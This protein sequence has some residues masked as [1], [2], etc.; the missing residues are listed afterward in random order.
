MSP[1]FIPAIASQS[2]GRAWH[3][4]LEHR[5]DLCEKYGFKAIELFFE[6]LEAIA[7]ALPVSCPPSPSGT[8]FPGS[9]DEQERQLAAA[10]YIHGLCADHK[11]AILCLQPFMHYEGRLDPVSHQTAIQNLHFWIRLAHRLGTDLIQIPSNF[12]PSSYCTGDRT[13]IVADLRQV[14]DI[15]LDASPPIRFAYEALCW[16][17]HID[18]W[19]AAWSIVLE[20]G[21][22]NFGTCIDT[23]NLAGRVFADPSSPSGLVPHAWDDL[24]R[25]ISKLRAELPRA[26]GKVFYVEVCDGERLDKP[27]LPGHEWYD[28]EQPVRMSWSRNA[29]LFPFEKTGYLPVLEILKVVCK[30]G[31]SGY[32]SF[33]L[34]SRTANEA[35][36]EVPDKHAQ[37]GAVAWKKL[38]E[39]MGWNGTSEFEASEQT[40]EDGHR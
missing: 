3:Q 29:R 19:D 27:L 28:P 25:S 5:L 22:P 18:T 9:T 37:R 13:R 4:S 17:T 11:L 30:A 31:Y 1:R 32:I 21:R 35:G 6:D 40:A 14:A 26:I 8:S 16:G 38:E 24:Q 23:F 12:L 10:D 34:F 7:N 20:V 33:E 39:H 36:R 15:G 2:L